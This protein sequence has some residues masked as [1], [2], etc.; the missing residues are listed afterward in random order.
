VDS[1]TF[2]DLSP[3]QSNEWSLTVNNVCDKCNFQLT[4][5]LSNFCEELKRTIGVTQLVGQASASANSSI[6]SNMN[7][8][9]VDE[10]Y[11]RMAL[12]KLTSSPLDQV[13][14]LSSNI[15]EK[16]TNRM[17][18]LNVNDSLLPL[19]KGFLDF[20]MIDF[21]FPD[22]KTTAAN[23]R[24]WATAESPASATN[25]A[26]FVTFLKKLNLMKASATDNTGLI[27]KL[28][29]CTSLVNQIGQTRAVAQL[30]REFLLE[31][32]FRY[33]SNILIPDLDPAKTA[34]NAS[35]LS[36]PMPDLSRCLLH[37][38]IQML[39]CCIKKRIERQEFELSVAR[40]PSSSIGQSSGAAVGGDQT[41]GSDEDDQFF[42]CE[43]DEL[44]EKSPEKS[45][46]AFA[47][48]KP[49]GRLKKFGELTLL[50]KPTE[51]MYVP[52]TQVS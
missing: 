28:A 48:M 44:S 10:E 17:R 4:D 41:T 12:Q 43:E 39:N 11:K 34:F 8:L 15:V 20:I 5:M 25:P 18:M 45:E 3:Q 24:K 7:Q 46:V 14:N 2:T 23:N 32:R 22:A 26:Q 16:A 36:T 37:Q 50:N 1:E 52:L 29:T 19:D 6:G 21:L 42:D 51:F 49:E 38:K 9:A 47:N 13:Y 27:N 31:L 40:S 35:Y 33:D 30:W